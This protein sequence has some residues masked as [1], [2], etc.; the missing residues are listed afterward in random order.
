[1]SSDLVKM[2][3]DFVKN[4]GFWTNGKKGGGP[5]LE[6]ILQPESEVCD[7]N[8]QKDGGERNSLFSNLF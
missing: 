3:S 4:V 5:N 7:W 6:K 1:M 2:S 8:H